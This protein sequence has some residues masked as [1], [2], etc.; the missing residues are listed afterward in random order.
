MVGFTQFSSRLSSRRLLQFLN[1]MFSMFDALTTE[2]DVYKVEIIG[3]AY[4]VVG[5][6]PTECADHA[7]R[8]AGFALKLLDVRTTLCRC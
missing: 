4:F 6:C 7:E 1:Q 3:D 5:G 2:Y 8:I